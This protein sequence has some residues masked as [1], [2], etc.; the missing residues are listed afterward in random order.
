MLTTSGEAGNRVCLIDM[1]SR[2]DNSQAG[3]CRGPECSAWHWE[4][5]AAGS[6]EDERLGYCGIIGC[7]KRQVRKHP[8]RMVEA[9]VVPS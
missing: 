2:R 5:A 1:V 3:R 6:P 9:T 7:V 4:A 8:R